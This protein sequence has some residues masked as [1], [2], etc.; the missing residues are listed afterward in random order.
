MA[1]IKAD[2]FSQTFSDDYSIEEKNKWGKFSEN[3]F[4]IKYSYKVGN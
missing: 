4:L 1:I 2:N 3:K